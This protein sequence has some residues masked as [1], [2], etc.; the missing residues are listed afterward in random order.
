MSNKRFKTYMEVKQIIQ[1]S[2]NKPFNKYYQKELE[3]IVT[4]QGLNIVSI[5][6]SRYD[7]NII[8]HIFL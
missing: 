7:N 3:K 4:E 2:D 6:E 5:R 1:D 8:N